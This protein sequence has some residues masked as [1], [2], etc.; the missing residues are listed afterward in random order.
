MNITE[1][2]TL[3]ERL[4]EH[5]GLNGWV[6]ALDRSKV[7]FGQCRH[8]T[9]TIGLSRELVSLNTR[10]AVEDVIRHEIAHALAGVE[11]GHGRAWKL[12]CIEVGARPERCYD[13]NS[14][15][16]VPAKFALVCEPCGYRHPRHRI[17]KT[18]KYIHR[19]CGRVLEW[20]RSL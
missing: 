15:V 13:S 18:K 4:I 14:V 1:A 2:V 3:A 12:K 11:A 8:R 16:A 5:F 7:R 10:E 19:R 20:E 6:V 9:H 17:T